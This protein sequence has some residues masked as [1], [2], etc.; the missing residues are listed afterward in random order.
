MT[1]SIVQVEKYY[2]QKYP[3]TLIFFR[4]DDSFVAFDEDASRVAGVLQRPTF[5]D[6]S[7]QI[8]IS[9]DY[10][11]YFES[12]ELL[13]YCGFVAK[14]IVYRND[15]GKFDVPDINYINEELESDY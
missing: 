10:N 5:R 13:S 14:A 2:H 12:V 11:E 3:G 15:E 4:V 6:V 9:L 1:S 7:G 8:T